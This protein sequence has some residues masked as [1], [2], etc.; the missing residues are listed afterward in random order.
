MKNSDAYQKFYNQ[1]HAT[2]KQRMDGYDPNLMEKIYDWERDEI[3]KKIWKLYCTEGDINVAI[4]LPQL[5]NYQG[6][7][8]LEDSLENNISSEKK[9][10]IAIILYEK[11]S[12]IIYFEIIKKNI[13]SNLNEVS[14]ISKL[15]ECKPDLNICELLIYVYINSSDEIVRDTAV[16][17]VL[18]N[19]G[20]I[21]DP[22]DITEMVN[23][24]ELARKYDINNRVKRKRAMKKLCELYPNLDI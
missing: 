13:E 7:K 2:G 22:F 14:N 1:I 9:L 3:E 23:K 20:I 6:M 17:G 10:I 11:T 4:F 16:T 12:N 5:R 24:V 15:L 21:N 18:Y 8:K 19:K